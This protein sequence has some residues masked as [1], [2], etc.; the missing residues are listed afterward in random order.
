ML[1][2]VNENTKKVLKMISF[3]RV[4]MLKDWYTIKTNNRNVQYWSVVLCVIIVAVSMFQ[5][6]FVRRLF[7]VH[8]ASTSKPRA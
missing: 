7:N 3:S 6:Y 4:Y 8:G 5:V 1:S 2:T